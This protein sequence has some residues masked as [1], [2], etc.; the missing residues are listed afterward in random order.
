[1]VEVRFADFQRQYKHRDAGVQ[2]SSQYCFDK[3]E[4]I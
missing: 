2:K 4:N 1:M 3:S